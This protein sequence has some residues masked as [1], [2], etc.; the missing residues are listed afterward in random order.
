MVTIIGK[1]WFIVMMGLVLMG[2]ATMPMPQANE[3]P[4][5]PE[6]M[7]MERVEIELR[8]PNLLCA[9]EIT[10][11]GN[12]GNVSCTS[13]TAK[14]PMISISGSDGNERH[15][16]VLDPTKRAVATRIRLGEEWIT[17]PITQETEEA[18]L[19]PVWLVNSPDKI[20]VVDEAGRVL[21]SVPPE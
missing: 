19:M 1:Q 20:E 16:I 17:V 9:M 11:D 13:P 8:E 12:E 4:L 14:T 6:V 18:H 15:L 2:C 7:R 3:V 5:R 10:A 21:A